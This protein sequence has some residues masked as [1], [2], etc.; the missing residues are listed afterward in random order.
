ML[1]LRLALCLL[2]LAVLPPALLA[3]TS[4]RA[5]DYSRILQVYQQR[6]SVPPCQFSAGQLSSALRSVDTYGAQYFADFTNAI[7]DALSARAG[8]A[9]SGAAASVAAGGQGASGTDVSLPPG[10][11]TAPTQADLPLPMILLGAL[12]VVLAAAAALVLAFRALAWEPAIAGWWRDLWAQTS[13]RAGDLWSEFV[14]WL[15]WPPSA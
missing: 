5:S 4:A 12:A 9:C 7:Q 14:D 1:R 10:P 2:A 8:G 15:R 3:P 13:D 11:V 6:G